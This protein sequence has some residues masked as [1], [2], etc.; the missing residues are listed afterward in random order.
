M[1]KET[2]NIQISKERFTQFPI[3]LDEYIDLE[4]GKT[5]AVR[6]MMSRFMVDENGKYLDPKI[7]KKALGGM[8]LD[9]NFA[10]KVEEFT[11]KVQEYFVSPT[12]AAE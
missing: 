12:N 7:A 3:T 9:E 8:F 2:I 10:K 1:E 11:R 5:R 4:E 6:D